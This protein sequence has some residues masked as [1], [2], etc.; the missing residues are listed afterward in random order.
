MPCDRDRFGRFAHRSAGVLL[1]GLACL[2]GIGSG[3]FGCAGDA[4][5]SR[6]PPPVGAATINGLQLARSTKHSLL[7]VKPDHHLGRYDAVIV[8]VAGFL[9]ADG[10]RPL[11]PAQEDEVSQILAGA[12]AGITANG[13]VGI[14]ETPGPCVVVVNIGL[15][16]LRLH[17]SDTS[18]AGS[19]SS[20]VSSF[21]SA[22]LVVE[23]RDSMSGTPL[24]R[25]MAA[26]GL[27][28]GPGMGQSGANLSRL[29]QTLGESVTEMV[30]ELATIVPSTTAKQPHECRDGI[31]A[32]TGR[33]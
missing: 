30:D 13:P 14:A 1:V 10:Q 28:G 22:T 7:W 12:L 23:F 2:V 20:F 31:Y 32:L 33:G 29:G 8:H 5:S 27:G 24:L 18:S 21:G 6:M 19:N 17:T 26:R 9:Y 4:G 15:K 16:D 11:E 25:Y 3:T